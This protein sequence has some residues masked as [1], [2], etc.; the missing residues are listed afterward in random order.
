[1]F[2]PAEVIFA[3]TGQC[4]LKCSH[5]RVS[6][7]SP[8]LS[9]ADAMAFLEACAD[10]GVERVG[11]SGGEPFLRPDFLLELIRL[12]VDRGLFFDRLMT[13]GDWWR[14][15]GELRASLDAIY[16]AGYDGTIGLS[17]DS[18]HAQEPR[19]IAIF[20]STVFDVWKRKD[21]IE[22][23]SV[24]SDDEDDFIRGLTQVAE[25]LGGRLETADGQTADGKTADGETV[26]GEPARIVDQAW[27][28]RSASSPDDGAGLIVPIIRSPR[29]RSAEEGAWDAKRWFSDDFCAGPGNVFYVHPDGNVAVCCG[30]AN[31]NPELIIG[32]ISDSLATL[33]RS[34]SE[35]PQV[36]A[37]YD[38]GLATIRKRLEQEGVSFPGKTDDM[39]FFCDYLCSRDR[40][41]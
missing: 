12:A 24:R 26:D 10:G 7:D 13:N 17:Y 6:R 19:R 22:I 32:T 1:M 21:L 14:D 29:S 38:L 4:N 3:P 39:C 33:M 23:L 15:E 37:C 8:E 35:K 34:A 2:K 5:C 11:F 28:S 25:A 41:G 36:K 18:Y 16:Q 9:V 40:G 20:M 31:E 30:F 27:L